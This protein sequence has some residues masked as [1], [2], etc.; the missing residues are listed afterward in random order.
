MILSP[1]RERAC[2][3]VCARACRKDFPVF[4]DTIFQPVDNIKSHNI[5]LQLNQDME[6]IRRRMG[7]VSQFD[8]L[9]DELTALDHMYLFSQMKRIGYTN[10][11]KFY[12]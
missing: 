8:V 3:F 12:N 1:T 10:E 7:V 2:F 6:N 5:D 9:W 4:A 11:L